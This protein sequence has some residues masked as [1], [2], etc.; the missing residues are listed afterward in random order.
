MKDDAHAVFY[1]KNHFIITPAA[2]C[3]NPAEKSPDTLEALTFFKDIIPSA[4]QWFFRSLEIVFPPF[5][6]DYLQSHEP[7][8]EQWLQVIEHICQLNLPKL[9][10]SIVMAE[11]PESR[12]LD[13]Q[14]RGNMT[15][16]RALRIYQMYLRTLKPLSRLK[17]NGLQAFFV[18]LASPYTF[19][20]EPRSL[21]H[22][23]AH[24]S[25]LEQMAQKTKLLGQRIERTV[26]GDEY[27]S[28]LLQHK[29]HG[30]SGWLAYHISSEDY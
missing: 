6:D 12:G 3:N 2:G 23:D 8:F 22:W 26:M 20:Q 25:F 17:E 30:M 1:A 19:M 11:V 18:T 7:A 21:H 15:K 24:R 10:L 13:D 9:S 4:A 14:C 5:P 16:K 27:D 29:A 28:R